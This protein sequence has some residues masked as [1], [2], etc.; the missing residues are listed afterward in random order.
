MNY[1]E[2]LKKAKK[3]KKKDLMVDDYMLDKVSNEMKMIRDIE[4]FDNIQILIE[5]NNNCQMILL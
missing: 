4:N 1:W 5:T 3:K 2:R